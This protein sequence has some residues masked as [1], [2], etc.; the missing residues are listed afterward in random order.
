MTP[1]EIITLNLEEVRRRSLK[2]WGGLP[3]EL[4]FWKPDA[5]A[6]HGL[7][8]IRHVLEADYWFHSIINC[9]GS[10]PDFK[11]PWED[12]PYTNLQD[13]LDFS[14]KYRNDFMETVKRFSIE[15]LE[16][17]AI[18]RSD[19]NQNRKLGDYLLRIAYH[20]SVHAGQF[21]SYLRTLQ[22]DRPSVWD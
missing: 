11:S 8:T 12:R 3:E 19:K 4:Y 14:S 18:I 2:L 21:L 17:I 1:T 6:M 22:I 9:R 10:V 20:E 15:E 16:T 7:E 13:E 5:T